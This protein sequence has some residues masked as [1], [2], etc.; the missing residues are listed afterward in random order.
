VLAEALDAG[1]RE[2][3]SQSGWVLGLELP[4]ELTVSQWADANRIIAAGTGPEPGR[5]STERT[6]YARE[7]M[8]VVNDPDVEILVLKWSSQVGKTEVLINVAGYYIAQDPSPQMFVLPDLGLA[9]S[10]SRN[11]FT[12]TVEAS[13]AL[14]E[15]I[16]RTR[17]RD[18]NTTILEKGY[19]G[20]DIVF[21]GANSP[22]S[23]ASRPRRIV[24][25]D[26]IDKYKASIGNDGDP[27]KQGFQRTQNFWNRK[28]LLASTPT[29]EGASAIDEWFKRSD[30]RYFE[31]SCHACGAFQSLEWEQVRWEKRK[32]ETA[33]YQCPH[34]E[35]EWDQ[36]Q[37]Y[38][39]VRKGHWKARE[40]FNGI[41]GFHIWAIYSPWVTMAALAAEWEDSEGKP[42]EEQTFVNLKLGRCYNP[43]KRAQ[44]T[45]EELYARKGDFGPA[46]GDYTVP[47]GVLLVTVGVDVQSDR[48]E[49]QYLGWGVDETRWVLDYVVHYDDPSD[50]QSFQRMEAAAL[51]R[52]F[53]HPRGGELFIE[54]AAIDAGYLQQDVLE[55]VRV[56][57]AAWKPYYACKGKDGPGRPII[58]ESD[59]KFKRGAKLY[60]MG[61]DDGKTQTYASLAAL[62]DESGNGAFRVHFARHLEMP[63]FE[64]LVSERMKIE[65]VAGRPVRKWVL[66]SGKRNEA[67]D[68]FVL[69]S[70]ARFALPGIDY[71]ARNAAR[72]G[73]VKVVDGAFLASL[74][75]R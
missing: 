51:T 39:A 33:R 46:G 57:R 40:A 63:Y 35:A 23:L 60:I 10:F 12:P 17:S 21:A 7:P 3:E 52:V 48:F 26:E 24:G 29:I 47:D 4:P 54:A 71:H 36:R 62:P 74:V 38:L 13:P 49:I 16:G 67:L 56:S 45:P 28:K 64:Q 73:E 72:S 59:E 70:A 25:F 44:T 6:P 27:I 42:G 66:P 55:F 22:A 1:P 61:V 2:A 14:L 41:A 5:W 69:A 20:G 50:P 18:S 11:R 19:P 9:D 30:Q 37:V 15:R 75:K 53:K 32:P 68:T 8:D 43:A 58:A 65:F 34:C 31:V